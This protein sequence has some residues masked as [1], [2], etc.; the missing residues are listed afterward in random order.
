MPGLGRRKRDLT[1]M[2]RTAEDLERRAVETV[3][4]QWKEVHGEL[5]ASLEMYPAFST[6]IENRGLKGEFRKWVKKWFPELA[7]Q[8]P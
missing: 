1:G 5:T 8:L 4:E 6:F 7:S 3:K 2:R